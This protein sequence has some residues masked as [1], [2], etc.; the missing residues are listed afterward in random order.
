MT[1]WG[2]IQFL[3]ER[4]VPVGGGEKDRKQRLQ[5]VFSTQSTFCLVEG[6]VYQVLAENRERLI[7][8]MQGRYKGPWSRFKRRL[9]T[10]S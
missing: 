7:Q 3:V 5:P 1:N 10:M 6:L 2:V 4:C 8:K 9:M